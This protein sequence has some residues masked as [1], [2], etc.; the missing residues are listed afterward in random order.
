MGLKK[1]LILLRTVF[2]RDDG[3]GVHHGGRATAARRS[4]NNPALVALCR[5]F[6]STTTK[7]VSPHPSTF[8][9]PLP[10]VPQKIILPPL[11]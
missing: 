1:G 2:E 3:R 9:F 5:S 8:F 7:P 6:I 10:Y 4:S 11:L